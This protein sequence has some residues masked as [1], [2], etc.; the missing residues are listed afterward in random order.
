MKVTERQLTMW[1]V[2]TNKETMYELRS[3]ITET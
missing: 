2:N 1:P 3:D